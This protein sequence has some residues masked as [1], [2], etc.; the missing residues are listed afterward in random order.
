LKAEKSL[1]DERIAE[2]ET[3]ISDYEKLK[4]LFS[5]DGKDL[6]YAVENV[7][8]EIGF[9]VV[10]QKEKNRDDFIIRFENRTAV[11]EVKGVTKSAS[12]KQAAQLEKWAMTFKESNDG[13]VK[14][15]LIVNTFK[16][17]ELEK[18]IEEDFPA[19]MLR[20]SKARGHCLITGVKLLGL[21]VDLKAGLLTG[22]QVAEILFDTVGP[23]S[24]APK[25][26][27]YSIPSVD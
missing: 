15:I 13:E 25:T 4:H 12:E 20:F 23:V 10:E 22:S 3:L 14:G 9:E 21:Y 19:Q 8:R 24:Y 18:R 7:F 2:Q 6:E 11:V 5:G 17:T 1:L 27:V 16:L 26:V